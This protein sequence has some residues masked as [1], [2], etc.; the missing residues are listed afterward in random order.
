MTS[1][2]RRW[3]WEA[4]EEDGSTQ[5]CMLPGG[6][7]LGAQRELANVTETTLYKFLKGCK[8]GEGSLRLEEKQTSHPTSRGV[9]EEDLGSYRPA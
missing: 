1:K 4:P 5:L 8:P 2:R 7:Q 9:E 6:M 3:S